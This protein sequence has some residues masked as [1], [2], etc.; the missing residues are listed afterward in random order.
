MAAGVAFLVSGLSSNARAE[1]FEIIHTNDYFQNAPFHVLDI[2][3]C[4]KMFLVYILKS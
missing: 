3:Y 4:P 2:K 1:F